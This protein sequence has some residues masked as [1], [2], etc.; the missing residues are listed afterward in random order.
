MPHDLGSK[1]KELVQIGAYDKFLDLLRSEQSNDV[2]FDSLTD[3]DGCTLLHWA[4][5]NNRVRIAQFLLN[6]HCD[7]NSSGGVLQEIPLQWAV[8][9][10][11]FGT[12]VHMLI[13]RGSHVNHRNI[14]GHTALH[15]AIAHGNIHNAFIL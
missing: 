3:P 14:Y 12:M 6:A 4:A 9:N 7:I 10:D 1:L 2:K 11:K 5:I 8:R 13:R 15:I